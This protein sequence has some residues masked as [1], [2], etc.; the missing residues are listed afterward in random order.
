MEGED[1][2][3]EFYAESLD[4]MVFDL[5]LF[6]GERFFATI[7]RISQSAGSRKK[8]FAKEKNDTAWSPTSLST[9]RNGHY[10]M[11]ACATYPLLR[12][13]YRATGR[14]VHADPGCDSG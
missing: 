2:R 4:R 13:R 5:R 14:G 12:A 1:L 9:G 6:S 3:C 8:P 11:G 7:S 10:R